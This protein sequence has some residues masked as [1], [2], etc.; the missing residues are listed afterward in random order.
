MD[1]RNKNTIGNYNLEQLNKIKTFSYQIYEY[2]AF[3][4]CENN[5]LPGLGLGASYMP[6]VE[7][8]KNA[9]DIDSYLKGIG[10]TNLVSPLAPITPEL[11]KYKSLNLF[12]KDPV[13]VPSSVAVEANQRPYW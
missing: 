2:S 6:N 11:C 8:S 5:F 3:G 13:Y 12:E 9:T 4:K 7:L 10:S 1:T